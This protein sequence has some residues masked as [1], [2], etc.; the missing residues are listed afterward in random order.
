MVK[1]NPK[2]GK[3]LSAMEHKVYILL[4]TPLTLVQIGQKLFKSNKT[5]STYLTRLQEKLGV[6]NR[7]ELIV[8]YYE[9]KIKKEYELVTAQ[10]VVTGPGNLIPFEI[11]LI[12]R[13]LQTAGITVN[14]TGNPPY[15]ED[16]ELFQASLKKVL[17]PKYKRT[18]NLIADHISWG[19]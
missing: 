3:P 14:I 2:L 16:D 19:E 9:T 11:E 7:L 10:I 12:K 4:L 5:I 18:V 15:R 17:D 13:A 8:N 6:K 1:Y